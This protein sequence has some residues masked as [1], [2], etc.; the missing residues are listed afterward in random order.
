MR[1]V[2]RTSASRTRTATASWP[3]RRR[4]STTSSSQGSRRGA[5]TPQP[6]APAR[7]SHLLRRAARL[8]SA[9]HGPPDQP[10]RGG[11]AR[12][13]GSQRAE[14][15]YGG[16]GGIRLSNPLRRFAFAARFGDPK[17]LLT[18]TVN[19]RSR[20]VMH[21][22]ARERLDTLAPFVGWDTHPQ[23]AVIGGRV[24]FLFH[25]YT[26]SSHYPYSAL[27]SPRAEPSST[28]SGPRR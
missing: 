18:Q 1:G 16:Q 19:T 6:T 8:R 23:T 15:H 24:K 14:Y 5:R 17:L 20:I 9:L 28:T 26:T 22:D 27:G 13:G 25:G 11:G 2:G 3:R 4:R 7:A 10:W 21:R 12:A